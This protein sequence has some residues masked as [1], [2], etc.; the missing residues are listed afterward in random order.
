MSSL[1]PDSTDR[2]KS[3]NKPLHATCE[4]HGREGRR[5][6]SS[7]DMS[8]KGEDLKTN[9]LTKWV[10][11]AIPVVIMLLFQMM[12]PIALQLIYGSLNNVNPDIFFYLPFISPLLPLIL[13]L[14]AYWQL[15]KTESTESKLVV[16]K[17]EKLATDIYIGIGVGIV[18]VLVFVSSLA[19]LRSLS[20]PVP[21][22]SSMSYVH[23]LFFS[24]IGA[25]VPGIGEEVYFRGFLM[26]KFSNFKP[27][28]LVLITSLSFASWHILSPAYLLHTFLVGV[29]LG[30][31][32]YR[33]RRLLPVMTAHTFAN[34]SAGVLILKGYI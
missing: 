7:R 23:H 10:W 18:C 16:T 5:W 9:N 26:R 29:I 24:T 6:A 1:V 25:I 31:T 14:I 2:G 4:T 11:I 20:Y 30:I 32:Y 33:T 28:L 15:K 3:H 17:R 8:F 27:A 19:V 34:M 22:F 21:D 13:F 12:L